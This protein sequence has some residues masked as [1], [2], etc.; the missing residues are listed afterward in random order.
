MKKQYYLGG[1]ILLVCLSV[2]FLYHQDKDTES[3]EQTGE[4]QQIKKNLDFPF[5]YT[6]ED[7]NV[8]RSFGSFVYTGDNPR[9]YYQF[10]GQVVVGGVVT[11]QG[12]TGNLMLDVDTIDLPKLPHYYFSRIA[13]KGEYS[14]EWIRSSE[15]VSEL[16]F[17]YYPKEYDAN[18]L[19]KQLETKVGKHVSVKIENYQLVVG[20][21]TTGPCVNLA[22]IE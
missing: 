11:K 16:C 6:N 21:K 8:G 3:A 7:L 10:S 22:E 17:G 19:L 1:L 9:G 20:G 18:G 4:V 12:G 5:S 14:S 13:D 15:T 2:F